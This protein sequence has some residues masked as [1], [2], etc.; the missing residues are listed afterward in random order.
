MSS[1]IPPLEDARKLLYEI[2]SDPQIRRHCE[3]TRIKAVQIANM[4]ATKVQCDIDLVEIGGLLH[5]IGRAKKHDVTHGYVG[6]QLLLKH[7]YPKGIRKIVEKHVLGGFTKFEAETLGLPNRDFIPETWEEK[8]VCVADKLR[9]YEWD[10][11]S[12]PQDW[13]TEVNKRFSKLT[14]HFGSGEPYHSSMER[15]RQFTQEL[16]VQA[17]SSLNIKEPK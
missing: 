5:D 9:I 8:I 4:I 13:L 10:G 7:Q 15:A 17:G 3:A 14:Q 12:Q 16:A 6:G 2:I 11:I 1:L